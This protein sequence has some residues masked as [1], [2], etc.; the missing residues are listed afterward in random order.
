MSAAG[1]QN[2]RHISCG[3]VL[4]GLLA[5]WASTVLAQDGVWRT[6]DLGLG[7][8]L[9]AISFAG[10]DHG[11]LVGDAATIRCTDS[12][13]ELAGEWFEGVV[14][15]GVTQDLRGVHLRDGL[16]GW[17]VGSGGVVLA[18][19]DG[20][21]TWS[22]LAN[23]SGN[24][25]LSAV[26]LGTGGRAWATSTAAGQAVL[27]TLDGGGAWTP[28]AMVEGRGRALVMA[29]QSRGWFVT[30]DE[31]GFPGMVWETG[32][33]GLTWA[34]VRSTG[35]RLFSV[36]L[37]GTGAVWAVGE[38]GNLYR[39]PTVWQGPE[40][41][42]SA[43]TLNAVAFALAD[44]G[45]AWAVGQA[46]VIRHTG[47]G[48]GSWSGQDSGSSQ[49]LLGIA[50][51][52]S[53][54]AWA[55]GRAG[56]LL[57]FR[58]CAQDGDCQGGPPVDCLDPGRCD[59]AT[60]VCGLPLADGSECG[61]RSCQGLELWRQTCLAGACQPAELFQQCASGN[62][63]L[64]DSCD[65]LAGCQSLP[66]DRPCDDG[67]ACTQGDR[68]EAGA[69]L[70]G[71]PLVC[72]DGNDCTDDVCD[73]LSGCLYPPNDLPCDDGDACSLGDRCEAGACLPGAGRV[74]CGHLDQDCQIGVCR[75]ADGACQPQAL[76][77]GG[78][79]GE[80][81]CLELRWLRGACLAGAC[82]DQRL[83]ED[84]G[85]PDEPCL[86]PGCD[87][88]QG[89]LRTPN[90]AACEDGD[91]CTVG[92][93]CSGGA[94]LPGDPLDCSS[95]DE[96]CREGACD[97]SA[98]GCQQRPRAD[99]TPCGECLACV[100]GACGPAAAGA[101][102]LDEEGCAGRCDPQ[103]RCV[104][105]AV[106]DT[107]IPGCGLQVSSDWGVAGEPP[108]CR[109]PEDS[110]RPEVRVAG[111]RLGTPGLVP[112]RLALSRAHP[113]T[114]GPVW[115][116]LRLGEASGLGLLRD[117]LR[118]RAFAF[119][120]DPGRP[121]AAPEEI[122]VTG[123]GVIYVG[124]PALGLPDPEP[125]PAPGWEWLEVDFVLET[126]GAR[127]MAFELE[128]LSP[129]RAAP[130]ERGC[131]PG[132]APP[133]EEVTPG[134]DGPALQRLT[135]TVRA[136]TLAGTYR[137]IGPAEEPLNAGCQCGGGPGSTGTGRVLLVLLAG[138]AWW[139]KRRSGLQP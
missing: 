10:P 48:G 108:V 11:C 58:Q 59:T 93:R 39:G 74:D 90:Q 119:E 3:C 114:P 128:A 116:A 33:G 87:P 49:E 132:Q 14:E 111:E 43:V 122:L 56:T 15:A 31:G 17:A 53:L 80:R 34:D 66:N 61:A 139:R 124:L 109:F 130:E 103:G 28:Y 99:G 51:S 32:D 101:A 63:C 35:Q 57:V 25:N 36:A 8:D 41:T 136:L 70:P 107:P 65:P 83:L 60:G 129:C 24:P 29:D 21:R 123:P 133:R 9:H 12:G 100:S 26:W 127:A 121:G 71:A 76:P 126:H 120:G 125:G 117:S 22:R 46:G 23:P 37:S 110:L 16:V 138:L 44:P 115:L 38:G 75:P 50:A 47:D 92:D 106:C 13:G 89:C 95:L 86:D 81:R 67:D 94:C 135:G 54:R 68:C 64:D 55:V 30:S 40:S 78:E 42:G 113:G 91:A 77:D 88:D 45:Q 1:K 62:A 105:E 4:I 112:V 27:R 137:P 7:M 18:T 19:A 131:H 69:C 118:V 52:S 5:G 102:C 134:P 6:L 20:G 97:P 104:V 72:G 82:T 85:L 96:P 98:G 73:P 2:T 84:C 79:C